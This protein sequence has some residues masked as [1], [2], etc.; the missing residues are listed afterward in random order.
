MRSWVCE[1]GGRGL[2][3]ETP[4]LSSVDGRFD[5]ALEVLDSWLE[6]RPEDV[7]AMNNKAALLLNSNREAEVGRRPLTCVKHR[8]S[9]V[10]SM[11]KK[12]ATP[13]DIR[14]PSE[15]RDV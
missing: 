3:L 7:P 12:P 1:P 2:I 14:A 11:S 6:R 9:R 5:E 4:P 8:H 13:D 10:Q 15:L